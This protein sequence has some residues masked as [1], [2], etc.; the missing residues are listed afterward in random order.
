MGSANRRTEVAGGRRPRSDGSSIRP[1]PE[2]SPGAGRPSGC[3]ERV[4]DDVLDGYVTREAAERDYG[5]RLDPETLEVVALE[6]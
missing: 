6:R 1:S 5:V 2:R 4:R 3:C